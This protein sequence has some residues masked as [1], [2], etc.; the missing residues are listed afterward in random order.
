LDRSL[1]HRRHLGALRKKLTSRVA[2]LLLL[3]DSGCGVGATTLRTVI[4]QQ[5]EYCAPLRY[6]SAHTRITDPAIN[7]TLRIVTRC[8]RLTPA[9]NLHIFAGFQPAKLRRKGTTFSLTRRAMDLGHLLH[10]ALTCPPSGNAH[11]LKRT[12]S[13]VPAAQQ[14]ISSRD[15]I[16]SAAFWEDRRWNVEWLGNTT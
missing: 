13:F 6:R 8:L 4:L 16:R 11:H 14:L 3:A 9:D 5:Q 15:K 1:T 2:L 7:D 12:H 10:S